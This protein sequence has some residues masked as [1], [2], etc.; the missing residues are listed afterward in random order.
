MLKPCEDSKGNTLE[1]VYDVFTTSK[2]Q[3]L[4]DAGSQPSVIPIGIVLDTK[5]PLGS[6]LNLCIEMA[7]SDFYAKNPNYDTMLHLHIRNAQSVLDANLAVVDLLEHEQVVGLI[8]PQGSTQDTFISELGQK[9]HVPMISLTARSSSSQN[10]FFL[11][12]TV[13]DSTQA[14]ALA[15]LCQVLKWPQAVLLFEDTEY[16]HQFHSH[17]S[18]AFQEAGIGLVQPIAVPTNRKRLTELLTP[19]DRQETKVFILHMNPSL[20]FRL[21]EAA[22]RV[23]MT[24]AGS[25]WVVTDSMANFLSSMDAPTRE[26]MEGAVGLRPHVEASKELRYFQE[27]WARNSSAHLNVIGLWAYDLITALATAVE[28]LG[29]V[30]P[31]NLCSNEKNLVTARTSSYG[32]CLLRELA[33]TRFQGLSG[34]FELANGRLKGS[35]FEIVNLVGTGEKV[36]GVWDPRRGFEK[37]LMN[38]VWPGDS[39]VKPKGWAM[40]A[41]GRLRVGVPWKPGFVEFVKAVIDPATNETRAT[42]FAVD[43]FL[44]ALKQMPFHINYTFLCYNESTS[45]NWSY[46]SMLHEIPQKYDMVVADTT[47]WAPRASYVDFTLPYSESGLV[48]V[49]KNNKPLNMWIFIKPLRWDLWLAILLASLLMGSFIWKLEAAVARPNDDRRGIA[50]F[51]PFTG[52]A[53]QDL[54]LVARKTSLF[55]LGCWLFTIFVLS[56]SY[57]ANLSAI[58]TLDQLHFS[59]SDDHYIG[60][61]RGSFTY[62]FLTEKL[63]ISPAR[64]RPY[65]SLQEYHDA[66]RKGSKRG[67]ID[68][69]F[70]ELPYMK[71]LINRYDSR[72]KMKGP[73]FRTDGLGFAL[74]VGS[75]LVAHF[76][77]AILNVTQGPEMTG[78][79]QKNFGPGY[80]SQDPL[81]GLVSQGASSL[82]FLDFAGLFIILAAFT[83]SA[84][85]AAE[86]GA[87]DRI[88]E[89][90]KKLSDYQRKLVAD[91]VCCC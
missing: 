5:S 40:P 16:G 45:T 69:I 3:V 49:V 19:L 32:S 57:T 55:V 11:R 66:M 83:V 23:G 84:F 73:T 26:A 6:M 59:F 2:L 15:S 22:K 47:I 52:M 86:I 64:L 10:S 31:Q 36:L 89:H 37:E 1:Q 39:T 20:G 88:R 29:P 82:T 68:A 28:K 46:D 17:L 21:I 12:A 14:R 41:S 44:Y 72:Y 75:P 18:S 50:F 62:E 79:E 43:I 51:V 53:F 8:G 13:D 78:L 76:S 35:G 58:L 60:Y 70:D 67:G 90:Y 42:G 63:S 34:S 30:S 80:S 24:R 56:Q 54:A 61:H 9:F 25:A 71:L 74:P 87:F 33:S 77:R 91:I 27:R 85:V 38:A 7:H 81:L 4:Q 65:S 48:L